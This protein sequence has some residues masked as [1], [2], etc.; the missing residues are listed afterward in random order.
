MEQLT[1]PTTGSTT[2]S[3]EV[4][5]EDGL[6]F[7]HGVPGPARIALDEWQG[8]E[9]QFCDTT[10]KDSFVRGSDRWRG[11]ITILEVALFS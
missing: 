2:A 4:R 9:E 5:N 8:Q 10:M 1:P 7:G 3:R 6:A 11:V